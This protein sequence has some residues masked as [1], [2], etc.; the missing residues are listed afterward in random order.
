MIGQL[1]AVCCLSRAGGL[2]PPSRLDGPAAAVV[3]SSVRRG[4]QGKVAGPPLA[5]LLSEA[6]QRHHF[7][8][9]TL[10]NATHLLCRNRK[11]ALSALKCLHFG[12][13]ANPGHC[14]RKMHSL[15][16]TRA[17][18]EPIGADCVDPHAMPLRHVASGPC[19]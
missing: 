3:N 6:L 7:H 10:H 15:A 13:V 11:A 19:G 1:A 12:Q 2:N 17:G 16:A 18:H 8:N 14:S 9:A 4:R 5:A